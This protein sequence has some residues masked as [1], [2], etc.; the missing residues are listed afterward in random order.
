MPN[1]TP[2]PA[3]VSLQTEPASSGSQAI[4]QV[5]VL[6]VAVGGK[7]YLIRPELDLS[8]GN[9]GLKVM[10]IEGIEAVRWTDSTVFLV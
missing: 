9:T 5:T 6:I 4:D 7:K 10:L 3:I 8:T 1:S 2:L